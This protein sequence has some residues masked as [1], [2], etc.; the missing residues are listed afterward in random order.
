[1][2][3]LFVDTYYPRFLD[4]FWAKNSN[5]EKRKYS[6]IKKSLL[7]TCF[8][9]S[10]FYSNTLNNLGYEADDIIINDDKLQYKWARENKFNV[11]KPK[12]VDCLNGFPLIGKYFKTPEWIQVIAFEQINKYKPDVVYMQDLGVLTPKTLKKI[13][14]LVKLLVGQTACPLPDEKNLKCFDLIIT[15]FPHYVPLFRKMGIKSEYLKLAFESTILKKIPE[16]KK[17]YDVS[18]VGSFGLH[19]LKATKVF[20]Q[21]AKCIPIH[22]WGQGFEFLSPSSPLRK[23]FHKENC[24][25]LDLFKVLSQSK[26]VLNRHIDVANGYA[27]NMRLFETTA[28]GAMLITDTKKNLNDLFE[29][30]KEV[31]EYLNPRDLAEKIKYYLKH[32]KERIEIAKNGQKKTLQRHNYVAR[33][34][35]LSEILEKHLF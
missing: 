18:F 31:V 33:M 34:K 11:N 23:N 19:H 15:S 4:H 10:N 22:V 2:R 24:F 9:T 17:I 5:L 6:Q 26:I 28:C 8:G 13:K 21:V 27:N 30:G 14:K 7:A 3:I 1:M 29:V 16:V 20:E 12:Y 25:G 35:E 32:D